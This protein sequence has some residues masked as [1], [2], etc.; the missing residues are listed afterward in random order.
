[1]RLLQFLSSR[2]IRVGLDRGGDA[3]VDLSEVGVVEDSVKSLLEGG[4]E[5]LKAVQSLVDSEAEKCQM[6]DKKNLKILA[7][8][9]NPGKVLCVGRF[10]EMCVFYVTLCVSSF[11]ACVCF[12]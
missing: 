8:V 4:V 6:L 2:G 11:H 3:V 5:R 10:Q 9:H 1:M 7:P 12:M